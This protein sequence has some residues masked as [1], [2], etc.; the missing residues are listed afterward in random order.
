MQNTFTQLKRYSVIS[1]KRQNIKIDKLDMS[2]CWDEKK[3]NEREEKGSISLLRNG[4]RKGP[5]SDRK[6]YGMSGQAG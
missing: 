3:R 6:I 4:G 1:P 5:L 2:S